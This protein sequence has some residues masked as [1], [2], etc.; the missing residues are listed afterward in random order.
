M[1]LERNLCGDSAGGKAASTEK[2]SVA[3]S[4]VPASPD[5]RIPRPNRHREPLLLRKQGAPHLLEPPIKKI[6][7][8]DMNTPTTPP[9]TRRRPHRRRGWVALLPLLL[10]ALLTAGSGWLLGDFGRVPMTVVFL[11]T[12]IAALATLRG[13]RMTDRMAVFS[14]GAATAT[15]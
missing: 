15:C 8:S 2:E 9:V 14:R 10:L 4:Y 7:T 11:L 12:G 5:R 13:Y 1:I 3:V 6:H